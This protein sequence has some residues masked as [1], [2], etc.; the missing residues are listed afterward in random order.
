MRKAVKICA[1]ILNTAIAGVM[2]LTLFYSTNISDNYYI[3]QNESFALDTPVPISLE[4]DTTVKPAAANTAQAI[5]ADNTSTAKLFGIIPIKQTK[6]T[7][8]EKTQVILG[9]TPFGIKMFSKGVMVV[10]INDVA[11]LDGETSSSPAFN[12]GIKQGDVILT[13]NDQEIATNEQLASVVNGSAGAELAIKFT[14]KDIEFN[15]TLTPKR[16]AD[17]SYKIGLWVRDSSAGIGTLTFYNPETKTYGGLGHG[18]CDVDTSELIPLSSGEIVPVG[19]TG[20][21]IA[22][23]GLPGEL[24]GVFLSTESIGTITK[25]LETGVFGG[26][27]SAPSGKGI[28][29]ALKQDITVGEATIMSTIDNLAPKE[30]S[31][32]IEKVNPNDQSK[33]KNMVIRVTD[34]NLLAATGGI[35]QGMS[36]SPIIQNDCLVGAVTHVFVHDPTKGYGVFAE[37]MLNE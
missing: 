33:T 16:G 37:T 14:R 35:V 32:Y 23:P 29:V 22:A 20:V 17:G 1:G 27:T 21:N 10:G 11:T 12:A 19:I 9:G 15:T 28:N 25:N 6:V 36:G 8:V 3:Y 31:V 4:S 13:I 30:Y 26:M 24:K 18:V 2:I 7:T 34:K 5:N